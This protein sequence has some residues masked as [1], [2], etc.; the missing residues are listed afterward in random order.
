ML[1]VS[2]MGNMLAKNPFDNVTEQEIQDYKNIVERKQRG[3]PVDDL[4]D[5]SYFSKAKNPFDNVTE[6]EIQDYKNIVER[7][8]RGEPVDDLP[9]DVRHLLIEP[10]SMNQ[11][12]QDITSP[13][14]PTSP[15]SEDGMYAHSM[16]AIISGQSIR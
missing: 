9:D 16:C 3:E 1:V 5:D 14:S 6:Q 11:T 8:Q 2:E 12:T 15:L 7:K 13:T 4:P 10:V